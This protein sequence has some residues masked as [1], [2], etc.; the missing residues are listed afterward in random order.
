MKKGERIHTG[1]DLTRSN[2]HSVEEGYRHK[3]PSTAPTVIGIGSRDPAAQFPRKTITTP[4]LAPSFLSSFTC[5]V[6][7]A[8][9]LAL[10]HGTTELE[11]TEHDK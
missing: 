10:T 1:F 4:M 5:S 2:E 7:L 3:L 8:K 6:C 11:G 9:A